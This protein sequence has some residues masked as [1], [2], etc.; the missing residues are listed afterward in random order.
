MESYKWLAGRYELIVM[1]G[2]GSYCEMNLK[3]NDPV[4]FS[5]AKA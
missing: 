4:N 5:I 2:A 1:E 3:E